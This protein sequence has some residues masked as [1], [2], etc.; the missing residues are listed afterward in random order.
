[1]HHIC[2]IV[3]DPMVHGGIAAVTSG[4]YGSRLEKD[5]RIT[6][7]QSYCDG[8]K[9][10]KLKKALK[11][12]R[13]FR[14]ILRKDPPELVHIHS[15]FGPSFYRK[16]PFIE[17]AAGKGIP[18]VN[19]IHGS[20]FAEF[21][22]NASE[23]KKRLVRRVYGRCSRMIVLTDHWKEVLSVTF[24]KER[25]D[26]VPNYSIVHPEVM[27]EEQLRLRQKNKEILYLGVLTEGKG[28]R[29]M[30]EIIRQVTEKVPEASFVLGGVGDRE[31]VTEGLP[32]KVQRDNV[33]FPGWVRGEEKERLL[34]QSMVFLLPSHMEAMPMSLLEAMGYGLPM[35]TTNV[36]GIPNLVGDGPQAQLADAGDSGQMA[37]ALIR[38][39]TDETAW[40]E[41]SRASLQRAESEYGFEK[42][43]DRIEAVYRKV[44]GEKGQSR[45]GHSAVYPKKCG[46]D[47]E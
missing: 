9:S 6:Y 42:H 26:V 7:V 18:V 45:S 20:A 11:A 14:E 16:L 13:Q 36:G 46:A 4:Y 10:D 12:Y 3:P 2:M 30:P 37:K 34:A 25:I 23:R 8:S 47:K 44:L 24:P 38:L 39:L 15:S 40:K 32:E 28:M 22:E 1:M 29:E 43:L 5:F 33:R 31:L 21:Y 41:A 17:M 19:H 35:V 27:E